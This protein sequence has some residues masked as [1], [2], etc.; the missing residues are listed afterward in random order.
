MSTAREY[1]MDKKKQIAKNEGAMVDLL[2]QEMKELQGSQKHIGE[3]NEMVEEMAKITCSMYC[4]DK[5]K[6]CAGVQECDFKCLQYN[7]CEA[8][9][10]LGYRKIPEGADNFLTDYKKGF[11]EGVQAVQVQ[12][13]E[14]LSKYDNHYTIEKG[15]LLE[16]LREICNGLMEGM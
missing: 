9:V 5:D 16:W 2:N 1:K 15:F 12:L 14:G 11:K 8:L 6:K 4:R 7:R 13:E 10:G 3:T